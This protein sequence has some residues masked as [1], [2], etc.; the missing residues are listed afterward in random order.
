M[1]TEPDKARRTFARLLIIAGVVMTAAAVL[2][3]GRPWPDSGWH[4]A[5]AGSAFALFAVFACL[6]PVFEFAR[7]MSPG[8]QRLAALLIG[9]TLFGHALERERGTFPLIDWGMFTQVYGTDEVLFYE[10]YG[11]RADGSRLKLN[12]ARLF[13]ALH[14]NYYYRLERTAE[15]AREGKLEESFDAV[16][17]AF[18]RRHNRLRPG[19]PIVAVVAVRGRCLISDGPPAVTREDSR[20]V[21]LTE[22][23]RP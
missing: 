20:R 2:A 3:R 18:G 12:G 10:Y 7:R 4:A 13:P 9:S 17:A 8:R 15:V 22:G 11:E 16:L 5:R 6:P 23:G 1:T 21:E 19:D 14:N